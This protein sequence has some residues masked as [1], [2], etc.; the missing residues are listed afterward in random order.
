M[1]ESLPEWVRSA[2]RC[3][4]TGA[5]LD[6]VAG[7]DGPELVSRDPS[8]PLAYPVRGGVPVMLPDEART[9]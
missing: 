2:L 1:T 8:E 7:P 4:E 6:D 9:I 3:P 5:E